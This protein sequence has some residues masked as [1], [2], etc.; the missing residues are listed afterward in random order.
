MKISPARTAAFDI[1]FRIETERAY[2][3]ILL[4][5][6][7]G[8]LSLA[9]RGLCHETVLGTLRKQLF[10]DRS[11][12]QLTAGKKIDP[13]IRI[14]LRIG[15]YQLKYLDRVPDH[16]AINESVNLVHRAKKTSAKGF[17]NAVLRRSLRDSIAFAYQDDVERLSI[18]TSHPRWLIDKWVCEFGLEQTAEF[19]RSNNET[20][21]VAFRLIAESTDSVAELLE[22]ARPSAFVPGCYIT[23]R[24]SSDLLDLAEKGSIYLQDE[25]SQMAALSVPVPKNGRFLDVCA[26]PGGKVTLITNDNGGMSLPVAGDLH[27]GRVQ[28]LRDNCQR[29]MGD[30][31]SILQYDAEKGLPFLEKSFDS[32]L[33][34]APCSGTGTIRHNPELRYRLD[35]RDFTTLPLKQLSILKNASKMVSPGGSLIYSTCSVEIEENEGVCE[36]FLE[37]SP[38]F[39][40]DE[41]GVDERFLT[42]K[43]YART[44]PH[45]DETDGF[46]IAA[47]RRRSGN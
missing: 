9:D 32:V 5:L 22:T 2:S 28:Y 35:P 31:V 27:R 47:F 4:P 46:F 23:D 44:W 18:E 15:I 29:L 3:S 13:Q 7:E 8:E 25:A 21:S 24:Y 41:P 6:Y 12:D 33:V 37:S 19:A 43:G 42:E 11:I 45:R 36:R 14:A 34:D 20:P 26:S 16:A 39:D 40:K 10:L 17:V 38:E 30:K 1:L